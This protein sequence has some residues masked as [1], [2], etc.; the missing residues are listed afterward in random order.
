MEGHSGF[1]VPRDLLSWEEFSQAGAAAAGSHPAQAQARR[2]RQRG[3]LPW[4]VAG[5]EPLGVGVGFSHP[6]W[7][8][9][10]LL[11]GSCLWGGQVPASLALGSPCAGMICRGR[12]NRPGKLA[13][14][15]SY[16]QTQLRPTLG[17]PSAEC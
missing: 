13:L 4:P 10:A 16:A 11:P 17:G 12:L 5:N 6:A 7:K 15:T 1:R 9:E 3:G 8:D 2:R 14:A